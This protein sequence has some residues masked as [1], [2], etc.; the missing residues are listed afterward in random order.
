MATP[1]SEVADVAWRCF[2]AGKKKPGNDA[3][4]G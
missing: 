4:P 2:R 3:L 1:G